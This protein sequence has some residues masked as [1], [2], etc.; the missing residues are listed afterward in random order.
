MIGLCNPC[1]SRKENRLDGTHFYFTR[2]LDPD[3]WEPE[4]IERQHEADW[5]RDEPCSEVKH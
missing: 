2:I 1:A 3:K 5:L 4:A